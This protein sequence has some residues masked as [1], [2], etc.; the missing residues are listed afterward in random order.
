MLFFYYLIIFFFLASGLYIYNN[1]ITSILFK[2]IIY[3]INYKV[4]NDIDKQILSLPTKLI[5]IS[6]HTSIY[7][8]I[9]GFIFYYAYLRKKYNVNILMKKEFEKITNPILSLFDNKI[10]LISV[11]RTMN[12]SKRSGDKENTNNKNGL[13][14]Q[15]CDNLKYKD[16]Y[17]LYIAPEGTRK[18][19]EQLRKGYWYIS[20]KLD[21]KVLYIGIDFSKKIIRLEKERDVLEDWEDEKQIFINNCRKYIPLYPERCYWTKNFYESDS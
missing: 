12:L 18:C 14:D 19:T 3:Y 2:N 15:I 11:E 20:K 8:F 17:I 10:N 6:S 7:D 16:N 13:T 21:I 4:D 5:I 9:I 1:D